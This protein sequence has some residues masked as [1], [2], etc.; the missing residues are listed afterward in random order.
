MVSLYNGLKITDLDIR[1]RFYTAKQMSYYLSM[2]FPNV[3]VVP[4]GSSVNGFGQIGC[5]LDL[6]CKTIMDHRKVLNVK[7]Y[8]NIYVFMLSVL[9]I[10]DKKIALFL[11]LQKVL[12]YST[13]NPSYRKR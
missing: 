4:F 6:L 3:Q 2:L 1:L 8:F 13:K 12:F 5:D 7:K 10:F 11:G 9:Y